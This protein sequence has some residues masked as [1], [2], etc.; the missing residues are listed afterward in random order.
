MKLNSLINNLPGLFYRTKNDKN[1]TAEFMSEGCFKLTGYRSEEFLNK[2][3]YLGQIILETDRET[4]WDT[5]QNALA[6]RDAFN[7][8][9]RM[10]HKNGFIL[11]IWEQGQGIYDE[12][13]N[14][15]AIE[16]F[17]Q[18]ISHQKKTEMRLRAEQ[19]KNEALLEAIPDTMFIQDFDGNYLDCFASDP[20]SLFLPKHKLLGKN[21][22]DVLPY[23]VFEPIQKAHQ[24][25]IDTH[26]LQIIEYEMPDG[27]EA[28]FFEARVI[29]LNEHGL[30]TI[31]RDM[32]SKKVSDDLLYLRKRALDATT[33]GIL[34]AD[35]LLSDNPIVYANSA[36]AKTTGYSTTD[37]IGKNCRFLQGTDQ[38]QEG[39]KI[40]A[41]AI[42][43]EESC[44]VVLRN[45]KKDGS[46]FW[47]EI[48]LTPIFNTQQKL[49]H[50]IGV[51]NDISSRK[52][53]EFIKNANQYV[54]DMIIQHEP[55][56][57]IGQKIVETIE[58]AIPSCMGSI[59]LVN[60]KENSLQ[61][62]T[63]PNLPSSFKK[64]IENISIGKNKASCGTAVFL[65]KEIIV[66]DIGKSSLWKNFKEKAL[67]ENLKSC[68]SFP[69]FSSNQEVLGTLAVYSNTIRQPLEA[70]IEIIW[71]ITRAASIAIE[72]HT[73]NKALKKS[74]QK[75]MAYAEELESKVV[76]RT[77]ELRNMVQK[78]TESNLSL[79]DQI[80]ETK[81]AEQRAI[82][83]KFLLDNISQ[84]FPKG[85][86][87]VV[88]SE[89]KIEF[90]AGEEAEELGF[91]NLASKRATFDMIKGIPEK[92]K[93][94]V[95]D[96]IVKTF[97]GEH[98]SFEIYFKNKTYLVNT[99]PLFNSDHVIEQVLLVHNNISLQKD[100]EHE[101]L[102]NL[103]KE[104]EL[105]EI[106]SRFI[107]MA[108]HE[109]RTP[110]SAISS[111]AILIEKLNSHGNELKRIHHVSKIKKN[112][113][114]LVIILNDFLSLSKLEEGK[115]KAELTSFDLIKFSE[116]ILEEMEG[117]KKRGQQIILNTQLSKVEVYLDS[118]LMRHILFNLL[119]NAIKYSEEDKKI[120]YTISFE[121]EQLNIEIQDQ[122]IGIPQK[123]Q[124]KIFERFHRAHNT[125]NIQGT[126]L[127]LHIVKHYAELM[128][129][130]I[131]FKS[132][133]HKGSTFYLKFPKTNLTSKAH[134]N[135]SFN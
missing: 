127:G 47:N 66:E 80:L 97:N 74:S 56:E 62:L 81:I 55:L 15:M 46:L 108:S 128:K 126:G 109:F 75:L 86:V 115:V 53:K 78:L 95:R 72:Q 87:A 89:I 110:L 14:L 76:Q 96:F 120:I 70:E 54:L 31:I 100:A 24:R 65:K 73:V 104:Q 61:K 12:K 4:I 82:K 135:H 122:G 133:V 106:K 40:M 85:F 99:T 113:K 90:I 58:T 67:S 88:N 34:I 21:M 42:K 59:F 98:C 105:G 39:V 124:A 51:Q 119:S 41:N 18:D 3:V 111:S 2:E 94:R 71:D 92:I 118:K 32:T 30:L 93:K 17:I 134:E 60:K 68:W 23:S 50:F 101:I 35:A 9:Y 84:N 19:E 36:V 5:V 121:E 123:D 114:N 57:G 45:Y 16:G 37:F 83:S 107:S 26:K 11:H 125:T 69:I 25:A 112:I 48:S 79:E 116:A 6:K 28:K 20:H 117:I 29:H 103:K 44:N 77:N 27:E 131:T 1:W 130:K 13:N 49:T 63:A 91:S 43:K 7:I 129:G 38:N 102:N 22:K 132:D 64:S 10:K 8:E 52:K 33:S